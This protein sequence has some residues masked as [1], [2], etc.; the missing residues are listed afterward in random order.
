MGVDPSTHTVYVAN[1]TDGTVS[2]IDGTTNTVTATIV[3]GSNPIGVG[4]DPSTHAVYIANGSLTDTVSVIDGTTNTVTATITVVSNP[5]AVGV[6]PSTHTVFV[7]SEG[8]DMSVIDG[9]S[10]TVTA[11]V[12]AGNGMRGVGVDPSTHIVYVSNVNV[13][14]V[15]VI[16][17][18]PG[19]P[20]GVATVAGDGKATVSFTPPPSDGGSAITGYTVTATDHTTAAKGGQTATGTAS[21]I[22]VGGLKNGDSYTFTVT[23]ANVVGSGTPSAPSNP[24]TPATVPGAPTGAATV[25]GAGQI[26]LHWTAPASSGGRRSAAMRSAGHHGRRREPHPAGH[27]HRHLLH[28]HRGHTWDQVLLHRQ[29]GELER[30]LSGIE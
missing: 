12:A 13:N 11:T 28:R 16:A 14:T 10:N 17:T 6:D 26:S 25:A 4:V 29:S 9:T 18:V 2:V 8:S 15:S 3:V 19:A 7:P 23:A 27:R 30:G 5:I 1:E 20:S 21:P 22:I 24:V